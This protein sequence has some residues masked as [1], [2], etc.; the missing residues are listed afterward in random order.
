MQVQG[1]TNTYVVKELRVQSRSGDS[2]RLPRAMD[3]RSLQQHQQE[4]RKANSLAIPV[5]R[6]AI[7][8]RRRS[9]GV[10]RG[11]R[12]GIISA[13][14]GFTARNAAH[15]WVLHHRGHA[16]NFPRGRNGISCGKRL[17]A[18]AGW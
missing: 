6:N 17:G 15:V 8:P 1:L 12:D 7:V 5:L 14:R 18:Y 10:L 11:G 9:K 4:L 3:R 16:Y 13:G 2:L